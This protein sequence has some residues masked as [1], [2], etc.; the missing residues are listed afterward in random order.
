MT[1]LKEQGLKARLRASL[2]RNKKKGLA[3][4]GYQGQ[5]NYLLLPTEIDEDFEH[6]Y[7]SRGRCRHEGFNGRIKKYHS[8]D[9][10]WKYGRS[11]H[12]LAFMAICVTLQYQMEN[13]SPLF[14]V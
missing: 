9:T 6:E 7:K 10:F 14:D 13:G 11:K 4:R 3:D 1:I 12:E 8:M 2:C 5:E